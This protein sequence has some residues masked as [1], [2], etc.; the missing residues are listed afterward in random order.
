MEELPEGLRSRVVG[1]PFLLSKEEVETGEKYPF[2]KESRNWIK[3]DDDGDISWWWTRSA[4]RGG[5]YYARYV[6]PSGTVGNGY[7]ATNSF[8]AAPACTISVI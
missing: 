3:T 2:Y 1:D 7:A 8:A 5:G 4:Y 6:Y